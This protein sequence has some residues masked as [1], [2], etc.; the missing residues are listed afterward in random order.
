MLPPRAMEQLLA[1]PHLPWRIE[2]AS[3]LTWQDATLEPEVVDSRLAGLDA[4]ISGI[5]AFVWKDHGYDP[6]TEGSPA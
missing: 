4:V 1:A 6:P 3:I 5:P 2:G